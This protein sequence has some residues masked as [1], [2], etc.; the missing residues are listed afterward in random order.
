MHTLAQKCFAS[1]DGGGTDAARSSDATMR[2]AAFGPARIALPV[3]GQGTWNFEHDDRRAAL[4]A[5]EAGIDAGLRHIDTAELYGSG[6]VETL[7]GPV[8]ARRRDELYVVSKVLPSNASYEGTLAACERSLGRLGIDVLDLYLLHW[9]G[10]YP[11]EDTFR[12][13]EA[14][15]EA[16]KIRAYGVSNF[17]VDELED[18]VAIAGPGRIAC[19]QV[20]YHLEQ[21]AIEHAVIPRCREL[22]VSVVAYSPLGSGR[23]VAPG[24]RR[25]R[26]LAAI[27][28]AHDASPEQIALAFL[29]AKRAV[30]VIPKAARKAHSLENAAA[31]GIELDGDEM[32]ALDAAFPVRGGRRLPML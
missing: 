22:D 28:A 4:E 27:A 31:A 18:A 13:F 24:S 21:R 6:S 3:V 30:F 16:G 9:P 19:N 23:F 29:I 17:D 10:S 15:R 25:G 26:M 7:I 12:A 8:V 1:W 11:L 5:L 32:Q 14:L 2:T 20:L